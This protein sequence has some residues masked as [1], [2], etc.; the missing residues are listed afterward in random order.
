MRK[1]CKR[2]PRDISAMY[3]QER[4]LVQLRRMDGFFMVKISG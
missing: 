1:Q 2:K 4:S 3:V